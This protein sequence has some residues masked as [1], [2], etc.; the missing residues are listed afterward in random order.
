MAWRK[1]VQWWVRFPGHGNPL[2]FRFREPVG[3]QEA[4][5]K[6]REYLQTDRLLRGTEVWP[7]SNY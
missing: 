3:E 7:D 6:A 1:C 4:R 2:T 5:Q